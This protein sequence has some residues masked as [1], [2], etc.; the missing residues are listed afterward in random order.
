M[1]LSWNRIGKMGSVALVRAPGWR[2]L[3]LSWNSNLG[4]AGLQSVAQALTQQGTEIASLSRNQTCQQQRLDLS[5]TV[6]LK[7][8]RPRHRK[9]RFYLVPQHL[10]RTNLRKWIRP[11]NPRQ[12]PST[13]SLQAKL[14]SK[15]VGRSLHRP[16]DSHSLAALAGRS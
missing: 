2:A 10:T 6:K 1:S 12:S 9:R 15:R 13:T 11:F 14:R 4:Y 3:N 7:S 5:H 16:K 8:G